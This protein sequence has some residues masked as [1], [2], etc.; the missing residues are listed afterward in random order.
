MI[1]CLSAETKVQDARLNA[2]YKALLASLSE[3]RRMELQEAQ[4]AWLKFRELNCRFYFDPEGGTIARVAA[5][6]CFLKATAE[7][8]TELKGLAE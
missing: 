5:N 3:T 4:R 8:A 1:E 2:N 7:R 6:Q